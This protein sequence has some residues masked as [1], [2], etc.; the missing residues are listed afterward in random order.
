VARATPEE[1][2]RATWRVIQP[3]GRYLDNGQAAIA[4]LEALRPLRL[5][6]RLAR[7]LR[8]ERPLGA[9]DTLVKRKRGPLGKL[10]P[11]IRR[12][13]AFPSPEAVPNPTLRV[14]RYP[15][16]LTALGHAGLHGWRKHLAEHVTKRAPVA[17]EVGRALFGA[18]FFAASLVYVIRT[19]RHLARELRG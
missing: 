18:F 11:N 10:V 13:A 15:M 4:L 16:D 6:G 14:R 12:H 19:L 9:L 2:R 7:R 8:L 1:E 3:D 5:V 17:D